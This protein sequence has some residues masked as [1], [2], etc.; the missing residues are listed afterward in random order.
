M[1]IVLSC[2][3]LLSIA[4]TYGQQLRGINVNSVQF[5]TPNNANIQMLHATGVDVIRLSFGYAPLMS[6]TPPY[7]FVPEAF[8]RL[9][10]AL[11][12]CEVNDIKVI[13]DPHTTPGTASKYTMS[14]TDSFWI[15]TVKQKLLY[16]LWDTLSIVLANR[17]DVIYGLDLMNEPYIPCC[18]VNLWN[19]IAKRI[20]D[21]IRANGNTHPIILE[22]FGHV[23]G[24]G[25]YIN[26]INSIPLLD[27]PLDSKLMLSPHFYAPFAFTHQGVDGA[28]TGYHYPAVINGVM[29]DSTKLASLMQPIK[30]FA[31]AHPTIKINLGEFSAARVGGTDGNVWVEDVVGIAEGEGWDWAYHEFR[32][33]PVWDPEMPVGSNNSMPRDT[34]EYRMQFLMKKFRLTKVIL[35][36]EYILL[37]GNPRPGGVSLSWDISDD[38]QLSTIELQRSRDGRHFETVTHWTKE[39]KGNI[40][41]Y[42]WDPID[43]STKLYY[44]LKVVG[45]DGRP[46]YSS[47][48]VVHSTGDNAFYVYPSLA[49]DEIKISFDKKADIREVI[50]FDIHG[51]VVHKIMPNVSQTIVNIQVSDL[52]PG[53]Y[54]VSCGDEVTK[55]IKSK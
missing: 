9:E 40:P 34:N 48:I 5:S 42:Y 35:P 20:T 31:T 27:L 11:D 12:F 14:P 26:R 15:D 32:G 37:Y 22:P 52:Q 25:N 46:Q 10:N 3:F 6:R 41:T 54:F 19:N 1:R 43:S 33:S 45:S 28:P 44:R 36:I 50:V 16:K 4:T 30:D 38:G 2:L 51:N 17:G 18:D 24:Q 53:I 39:N 13:V 8:E 55:F 7:K 21:T 47:V 49:H 29:Y 23:D